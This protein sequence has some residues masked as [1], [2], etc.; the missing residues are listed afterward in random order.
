M[1]K[2]TNQK[3]II[4]RQIKGKV[5]SASLPKTIKVEVETYKSHPL[6]HKRYKVT[7]H[8]HAHDPLGR[9]KKGD[10]VTI[11]EG[12]PFSKQK[13]FCVIYSKQVSPK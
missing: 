7:K 11:E 13:R 8:Y 2:T 9:C 1:E 5:I 12:R 6:Y 4:K 10:F 3:S